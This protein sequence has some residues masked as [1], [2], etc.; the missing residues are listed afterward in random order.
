MMTKTEKKE[1]GV[2]IESRQLSVIGLGGHNY[3]VLVNISLPKTVAKIGQSAYRIKSFSK[4]IL[5][6][7]FLLIAMSACGQWGQT[8]QSGPSN[9]HF[10]WKA[11][12]SSAGTPLA[13]MTQAIAENYAPGA[14]TEDVL[15]EFESFQVPCR[16][17]KKNKHHCT[18]H[19]YTS[20]T[21]HT[22]VFSREVRRKIFY[23]DFILHSSNKRLVQI[24]T[25]L[26]RKE[27]SF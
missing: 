1:L 19:V 23:F 24:D 20:N 8:V 13:N 3:F 5:T 18:Y 12:R 11:F 4:S 21:M 14:L 17:I 9:N 7:S 25:S 26:K 16:A 27:E 15:Q 6:A 2:K 10:L 22:G